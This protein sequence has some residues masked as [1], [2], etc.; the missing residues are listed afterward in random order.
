MAMLEALGLESV[1]ELFSPIPPELRLA[2]SLTIP[3][4]LSDIEL[5]QRCRELASQNLD[6]TRAPCFAG[7][8]V[9]DH[10]MPST[11]AHLAYRG[12]F[13]TAYTAYQP[14]LSQGMLAALFEF[15]TMVCELTGMDVSNSSVYDGGTA[16][17]E[18]AFVAAASTKRKRVLV[19]STVN[20][21]YVQCLRTG[22]GA[23]LGIDVAPAEGGVCQPG[24]LAAALT[25]DHAAVI[26]QHP[27]YFGCLE[28]VRTIA[29]AAHAAGA[30]FAVSF[31]PI[32]LGLLEAPGAYGADI[33][34]GEGGSMCGPMNLGGPGLGLF[35]CRKSLVRSLPGRVVGKTVDHDGRVGYVNTLQT[36]EQHIRRDKATSNICT[37]QA[38]CAVAAGVYMATMGPS[39]IRRVGELCLQKAHYAADR[40]ARLEGF[41]LAFRAPFFKEFVVRCPRPAAEL[42]AA[43]GASGAAVAGVDVS[44]AIGDGGDY[45][46]IAV[47]EKR[48]RAEIDA[49]VGALGAAAGVSSDA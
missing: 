7:T 19:A 1:E 36:R 2:G 20:P 26:V 34:V 25:A 9:Y 33:A 29:E 5:T 23:S 8:G 11:V 47:T 43:V 3:G 21:R 10:F 4:P 28:Q 37:N 15:Q 44:A 45:L 18:A 48:S 22:A 6:G 32:S 17:T 46:A 31:D 14:E 12:E 16:L 27:N 24:A 40:I 39:G 30:L 35:T 38:L 49:L 13:A 41:E 42:I